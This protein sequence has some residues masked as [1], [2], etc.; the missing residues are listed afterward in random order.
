MK[1]SQGLAIAPE[2]V[3]ARF[4]LGLALRSA[5]R[6]DEGRAAIEAAVSRD[7]SAERMR[8]ELGLAL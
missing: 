5:G 7:P 1:L 8:L 2:S 4:N 3:D 6:W